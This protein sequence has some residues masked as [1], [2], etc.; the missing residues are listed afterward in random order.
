MDDPTVFLQL[1]GEPDENIARVV[2]NPGDIFNY[3]SPT[4]WINSAIEALTGTDVIGYF[5][6]WVGGDWASIYKFGDAL[7]N[8]AECMQQIGV[9]IQQGM[10]FL[11]SDWDGNANDAA[12]N[13]FTS[14]A[15]A[16][17]GQ[18]MAL[19]E[20]GQ[21][22]HKAASGAYHVANALG[23]ILQALGDKAVLAGIVGGASIAF[24]STGVGAVAGAGGYVAV[25]FIVKD[26]INLIN[27]ANLIINT[28]LTTIFASF[29]LGVDLANQGGA[30]LN[31]P[32]PDV[33]YTA[34]GV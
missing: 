30:P 8:L 2:M 17:S 16:A 20:A 7:Y 1:P 31:V 5:T 12:Y 27:K 34:P 32:L 26:M 24:S 9:N 18:Q 14:F 11:D 3:A 21:E 33:L 19:F 13:Y 22:Y 10:E 29:G 6:E 4:A 25:A 23:N 15:S 28:A